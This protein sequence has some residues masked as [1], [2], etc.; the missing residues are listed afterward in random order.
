MSYTLPNSNEHMKTDFE[1]EM[2]KKQGTR[3]SH[4]PS[5]PMSYYMNENGTSS[6]VVSK[7][8]SSTIE[9]GSDNVLLSSLVQYRDNKSIVREVT[10]ND[11]GDQGLNRTLS[12]IRT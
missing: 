4:A 5:V 8:N 9:N 10:P 1:K 2:L 12:D 3:E 11:Q 6:G 7:K